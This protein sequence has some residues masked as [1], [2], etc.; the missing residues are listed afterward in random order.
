M[1]NSKK[2]TPHNSLLD[3]VYL[4]TSHF[5]KWIHFIKLVTWNIKWNTK[6]LHFVGCQNKSQIDQRFK[7]TEICFLTVFGSSK[8]RSKDQDSYFFW[9][10]LWRILLRFFL[11]LAVLGILW[12]SSSKYRW[13]LC[14]CQYMVFFSFLSPNFFQ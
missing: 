10:F 7:T 9:L 13:S 2:K 4:V 1:K 14:L 5:I 8:Q 6:C 3:S 12:V 11:L